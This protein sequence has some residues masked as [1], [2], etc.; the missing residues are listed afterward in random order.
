MLSYNKDEDDKY[1]H[2]VQFKGDDVSQVISAIFSDII[3][4]QL[5][6]L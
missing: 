4:Q 1:H 5:P 3:Q 2:M 6:N